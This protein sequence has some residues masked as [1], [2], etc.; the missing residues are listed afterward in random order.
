MTPQAEMSGAGAAVAR[1]MLRLSNPEDV[2]EQAAQWL[3]A[4]A[5]G[6]EGPFVLCLSGGETPRPL[7]QRLAA[8]PY[9][10][11]FPWERTHVFWGDERFVPHDDPRSNFRMARDT[12][13]SRAPLPSQNIHPV[14]SAASARA[15]AIAYQRELALFY[16][17]E[18]LTRAR[19]LFDVTLLG[20]GADGH[21][22]SLFPGD[23]ALCQREGWT[24]AVVGPDGL[25]RVALTYPALDNSRRIAFLVTGAQKSAALAR[26]MRGDRALP[27]TYLRPAGEIRLF[28]DAAAAQELETL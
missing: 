18:I 11:A 4:V 21:M 10:A 15:A 3:L 13:L 27:A 26:L 23:E 24:A 7:Y 14:P 2:A 25:E 1:Q 9:R 22:G 19:P 16:G 12:L 8:P 6:T 20:L 5:L 28:V 17:S